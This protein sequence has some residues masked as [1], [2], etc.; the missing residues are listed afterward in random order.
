MKVPKALRPILQK[1]EM[2]KVIRTTDK[3]LAMRQAIIYAGK[4][5]ELFDSLKEIPVANIPFTKIVIKTA[6]GTEYKLDPKRRKEELQDLIDR[7]LIKTADQ[8]EN[9][10]PVPTET[11][12]PVAQEVYVHQTAHRL[13]TA[14]PAPPELMLSDAIDQYFEEKR[15]SKKT[16][17]EQKEK[18]ARAPFK[19]LQEFLVSD[20]AISSITRKEAKRFREKLQ[21]LPRI[22]TSAARQGLTFNQ[23]IGT[24]EDTLG[25]ETV[26]QRLTA[27][28][29]LFNWLIDEELATT[30][31]FKGI[32]LEDEGAEADFRKRQAFT[33]DDVEKIFHLRLWTEKALNQTWEYWLPLLL[34][35]T[36][37]RVNELCQLERKDILEIDG[38]QCISINDVAT[39][40]EPEEV[41]WASR[42]R[43]KNASSRRDIPIHSKL[44]KLGFLKFS[45]TVKSGRIFPTI[46]PTGGKLSH[47]PCK[48]FNEHYL[49]EAGVKVKYK[50]T[51]YSFRHTVMN[52][53][54]KQKVDI[55]ERGQ[56]AG[57]TPSSMTERY[58]DEY[59]VP[60]MKALIEKLDFSDALKDVQPW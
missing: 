42:K 21:L 59:D 45:E 24:D 30:N 18:E 55:E 10:R 40:D 1:C 8:L 16:Y 5:L 54:K 58:G 34:L 47:Y 44:I 43:V 50:K 26:N 35:H 2:K 48:R 14:V 52:E 31:P 38:V 39:K 11:I 19:L 51:F 36:G 7:G 27:I 25:I 56:L 57:H 15:S 60:F 3:A 20:R 13:T 37:A 53:L 28:S 12:T 23:L 17:T 33:T 22:R 41:W 46:K 32:L 49:V 29:G 9:E 4:C 6:D